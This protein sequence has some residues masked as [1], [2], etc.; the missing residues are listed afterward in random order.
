MTERL[1]CDMSLEQAEAVRQ[2]L[3]LATRMGLGQIG[4][5]AH[6]VRMGSIRVR[7]DAATDGHR[8]ATMEECERI[9]SLT[10]EIARVLGH[11]SGGSFGIG[12][13][14]VPMHAKRQYETGKAIAKALADRRDPGGMSVHHDGVGVRYA[15]DAVTTASIV[16]DPG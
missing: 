11:P 4:E 3:D 14:G 7:D 6:L 12:N 16:G 5:I 10:T 15:P 9:E 8:D 13:R 2:G 1:H